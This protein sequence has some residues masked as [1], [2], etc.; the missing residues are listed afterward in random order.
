MPPIGESKPADTNAL[1]ITM[2][3]HDRKGMVYELEMAG[4]ALEVHVTPD[5]TGALDVAGQWMVGAQS[6]RDQDAVVITERA[7]TRMEALRRVG[8]T[9][10]ACARDRIS[11]SSTG[12]RSRGCSCP[13]ERSE[14]R[15][16]GAAPTTILP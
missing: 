6:S 14:A 15:G 10:T 3:Y 1:R 7:P 9:W 12:A 11:R 5:R 2:Q 16:D 13:C 4:M 8:Q